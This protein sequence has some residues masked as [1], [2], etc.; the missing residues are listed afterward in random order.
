M[1]SCNIKV[2]HKYDIMPFPVIII[3]SNDN[4]GLTQRKEK[5]NYASYHLH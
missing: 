3:Q 4:N 2:N 5:I 1:T